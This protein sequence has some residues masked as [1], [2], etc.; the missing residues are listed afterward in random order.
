M[1]QSYW[2]WEEQEVEYFD[3]I[4]TYFDGEVELIE[5][6]KDSEKHAKAYA[7]ELTARDAKYPDEIQGSYSVIKREE[8]EEVWVEDINEWW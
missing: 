6:I 7:A 1:A 5:S 4:F 8:I 3:V 2:K